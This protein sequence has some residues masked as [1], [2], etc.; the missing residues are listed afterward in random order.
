MIK[1]IKDHYWE[2]MAGRK[3]NNDKINEAKAICSKETWGVTLGLAK[4]K[5]IRRWILQME[6]VS[7]DYCLKK[8]KKQIA[9]IMFEKIK[10]C[11]EK[12]KKEV[13][14]KWSNLIKL[15]NE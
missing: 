12:R 15:Q 2:L 10:V 5:I 14:A 9:K 7:M 13:M 4:L 11:I 1:N 8:G 6:K 3:E